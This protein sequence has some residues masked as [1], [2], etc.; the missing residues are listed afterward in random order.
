MQVPIFFLKENFNQFFFCPVNYKM[1]LSRSSWA[2][3]PRVVCANAN[4]RLWLLVLATDFFGDG[5][6]GHS[7]TS[8]GHRFRLILPASGS[9]KGCDGWERSVPVLC[10][11]GIVAWSQESCRSS[12]GSVFAQAEIFCGPAGKVAL[13]HVF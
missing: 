13:F 8:P 9:G 11:F 3:D 6:A 7:P 1:Q 5:T 2:S 10:V 4:K 12:K